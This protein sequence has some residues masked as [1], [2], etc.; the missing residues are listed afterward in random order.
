MTQA[1]DNAKLTGETFL[2]WHL[3]SRLYRICANLGLQRE[4]EHAYNQAQAILNQISETI[5][6]PLIR[7]NFLDHAHQ[8]LK[9]IL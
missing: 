3:Q 1:I 7:E 8:Q 9:P 6:D 5:D 2:L 4:A